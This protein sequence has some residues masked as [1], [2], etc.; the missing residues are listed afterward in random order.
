MKGPLLIYDGDCRF[1]RR[2]VG[3]LQSW[4][5]VRIPTRPSQECEELFPEIPREEFQGALQY[6]DR[7]DRRHSAARAV[8]QC[9]DDHRI[10]GWPLWTYEHVPGAAEVL[11]WGY[12]LV[13]RNR[14]VLS[15]I[16]SSFSKSEDNL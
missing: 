15:K 1:C 12:R 5:P 8:V 4:A 9:M 10:A 13:A 14:G 11:E 6:I 2:S 7:R 16:V 3:L